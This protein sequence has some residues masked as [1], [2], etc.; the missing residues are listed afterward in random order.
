[1]MKKHW[2][3]AFKSAWDLRKLI[4]NKEI[5]PVELVEDALSRLNDLNP[6]LN[7]FLE[8]TS[9]QAITKAKSAEQDIFRNKNIGLLHGIPTSIKDHISTA[10]IKTTFGSVELIGIKEGLL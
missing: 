8:I 5:S 3:L 2:E 7:A 1:M 9:E 10:G 6:E 4:L